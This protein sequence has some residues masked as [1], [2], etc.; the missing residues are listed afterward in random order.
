MAPKF[1][2]CQEIAKQIGDRRIDKILR[3]IFMREKEAYQC[4]EKDYNERIEE[5][6]ARIDHR[7]G[8]IVELEKYELDHV[9]DES[10]AVLKAAEKDDL[11]DRARLVQMSQ[12]AALRATEKSRVAKKMKIV[13]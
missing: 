11:A 4:D 9:V 5:L 1:P 2:K 8:I 13:E 6:Q 7:H 3:E 12:M 10:L